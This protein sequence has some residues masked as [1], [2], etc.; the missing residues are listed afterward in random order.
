[1]SKG[2]EKSVYTIGE[3]Q[4]V[5]ALED[6]EWDHEW[7]TKNISINVTLED[8]SRLPDFIQYDN[9]SSQFLVY[10]SNPSVVDTY[11]VKVEARANTT[12]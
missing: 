4:L 10:T 3:H 7:C 5:V 11:Q 1:M 12:F 9:S 6:F 8:G 2:I